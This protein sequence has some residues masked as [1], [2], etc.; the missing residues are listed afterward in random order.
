MLILVTVGALLV[1]AQAYCVF[2]A[3]AWFH[4]RRKYT[5]HNALLAIIDGYER[6]W[7]PVWV[8]RHWHERYI[9]VPGEGSTVLVPCR[10]RTAAAR[11][12]FRAPRVGFRPYSQKVQ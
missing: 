5:D 7:N 2:L 10:V 3:V 8:W 9:Y 11:G 1:M 4:Q 6:L 12:V